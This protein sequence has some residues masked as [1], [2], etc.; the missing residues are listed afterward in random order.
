M[1]QQLWG[2]TES[3]ISALI[4][5]GKQRGYD[6]AAMHVVPWVG[7]AGRV[8]SGIGE[9]GLWGPLSSF[10]EKEES[11]VLCLDHL[12]KQEVGSEG[13]LGLVIVGVKG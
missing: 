8:L 5:R 3:P 7:M 9:A 13:M 4:H 6:L 12:R 11:P 1:P 10:G 2:S